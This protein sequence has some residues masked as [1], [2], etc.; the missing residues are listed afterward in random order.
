MNGDRSLTVF[1]RTSLYSLGSRVLHPRKT[2]PSLHTAG[3]CPPPPLPLLPTSGEPPAREPFMQ[4]Q[5]CGKV[6]SGPKRRFLMER[7]ARTHT[8]E[9]PYCC[10]HCPL[11]FSQSGN[12]TRHT[13][14]V[15]LPA[16]HTLS[17]GR[18]AG[19]EAPSSNASEVGCPYCG[20][21]S[22]GINARQNLHNHLLTHTGEK[23]YQCSECPMRCL[24]KS[25][26]KRH[27]L[28]CHRHSLGVVAPL[29]RGCTDP[30]IPSDHST[31]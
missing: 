17:S 4:C 13:R 2:E 23:P 12:L 10:P 20:F 7:H 29:A 28:L 9:K 8:G 16:P 15:H 3:L 27:M 31:H 21:I 14:L 6:F 18:P 26:L 19:L 22:R 11:R 1:Q 24:K 5:A 25:N 30:S